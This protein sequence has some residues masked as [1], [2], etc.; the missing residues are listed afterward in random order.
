MSFVVEDE[1]ITSQLKISLIITYC[2]AIYF[3]WQSLCEVNPFR[4]KFFQQKYKHLSTISIIPPYWYDTGSWNQLSWKKR[5]YLFYTVNI[6]DADDRAM[7]GERASATM[8]LIYLNQDNSV[9]TR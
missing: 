6:M 4:A 8:I 5:T 9:S 3:S 7:Q 2:T 1:K